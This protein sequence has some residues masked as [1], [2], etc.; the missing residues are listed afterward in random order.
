L[1]LTQDELIDL[2]DMMSHDGMKALYKCLHTLVQGEE[3]RV[4]HYDLNTL[5]EDGLIRLKLRT[6]GAAKLLRDLE[7]SLKALKAKQKV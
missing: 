3:S 7:A 5:P 4:L 6:E 2:T 1:K